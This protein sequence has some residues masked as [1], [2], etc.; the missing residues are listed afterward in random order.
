M[1]KTT[2]FV[3]GAALLQVA[4]VSAQPTLT[5]SGITPVVGDNII[6]NT[7]NYVNPGSAGANQTWN[8]SG[9]TATG[10]ATYTGVTPA[11]TPNGASFSASTVAF[12]SGNS[13]TYY[14]GTSSAWQY[15]GADNGTLAMVYSNP[16]DFLHFPFT[17]NNTFTDAWAT[18]FTNTYTFY[19]TGSTTATADGYGTLTTPDGTFTGV[20]RVHFVQTYQDSA[21]IMSM[22]Y[23]ITYQN[24]EYMWYLNGNHYP[25]ATVYT[26]TTSVSNPVTG[27][28]YTSNVVGVHENSSL[29][30]L[31]FAPNPAND[32]VQFTFGLGNAQQVRIDM[33]NTAGQLVGAPVSASGNAGENVIRMDVAALPEGIYFATINLDGVPASTEKIV[34]TR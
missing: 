17:F 4:I 3:F 18:S 10:S 23:I 11:S 14:K 9:M 25:I 16:E 22:P 32:Q 1:K 8:L 24:D 33:F 21:N 34:I 28:S 5:A 15:Y 19:R 6:M 30:S 2:L 12:G 31:S 26:L 29:T 20:T 13:Y 7:A 27:G